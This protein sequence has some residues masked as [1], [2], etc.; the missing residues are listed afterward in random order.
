M[1][2]V[3]DIRRAQIIHLH[4]DNS[5]YLGGSLELH[6]NIGCYWYGIGRVSCELMIAG[7]GSIE[8][9]KRTRGRKGR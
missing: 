5:S 4:L 3:R 2:V 6:A 9:K 1:T 7:E 8:E